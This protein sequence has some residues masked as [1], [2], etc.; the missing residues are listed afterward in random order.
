MQAFA[1]EESFVCFSRLENVR[2]ETSP[3]C[4]T[5]STVVPCAVL[6]AAICRLL[7]NMTDILRLSCLL[8]HQLAVWWYLRGPL[9]LPSVSLCKNA[10]MCVQWLWMVCPL[11]LLFWDF[12]TPNLIGD[13]FLAFLVLLSVLSRFPGNG[14]SL[15]M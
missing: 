7:P 15:R 9:Y 14:V 13:V 5:S 1:L 4:R 12:L 11:R 3:G 10:G 6:R 2:S 8:W